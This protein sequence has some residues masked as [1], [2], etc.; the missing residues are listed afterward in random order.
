MRRLRHRPSPRW[1]RPATALL[2]VLAAGVAGGCGSDPPSPDTIAVVGDDPVIYASFSDYVEAETD[3]SIAALESRV[4]S[5]L[6]DQYLTERLLVKAAVERGLVPTGTD[7]R[8]A[9][10]ALIRSAPVAEPSQAEMMARY[11]SEPERWT[12][13]ERVRL[14]QILTETRGAAERARAEVVDG[15]SFGDVARR[16]SI[17]PSAP[18]GGDQG[19]LSRDDLPEELADVIFALKP[20]EVS[21]IVAADYGF[22]VFQ[23][24]A[25]LPGRTVPFEEA[26]PAI[27]DSL[28]EE[29]VSAWI[30]QVVHDAE[31]R[32]T[33][34]VYGRNLPFEYQGDHASKDS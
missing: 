18:Y 31:S 33:V 1:R 3:S 30:D 22:H 13:P 7:H 15:A 26:E 20:G 34:Q 9:L 5:N 16:Y 24:T 17:D 10:A 27:R 11:R 29:R 14:R 19:E 4:L 21:R 25:R 32:Y 8:K 23:V 28:H 2:V 6:L 12:L